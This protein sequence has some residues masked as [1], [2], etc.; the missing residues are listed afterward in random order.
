MTQSHDVWGEAVFKQDSSVPL[1]VQF[2]YETV[3]VDDE[4]RTKP[5]NSELSLLTNIFT[6][7][8]Y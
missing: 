5:E 4:T 6:K 7:D 1:T 3:P 2:C 8:S